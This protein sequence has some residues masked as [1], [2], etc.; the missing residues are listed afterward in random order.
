[1]AATRGPGRPQAVHSGPP[2]PWQTIGGRQCVRRGDPGAPQVPLGGPQGI[3]R[4]SLEGIPCG[5]GEGPKGSQKWAHSAPKYMHGGTY[6]YMY[7]VQW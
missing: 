2:G 6:A 3:P 7:K 1:M 4:G 5:P